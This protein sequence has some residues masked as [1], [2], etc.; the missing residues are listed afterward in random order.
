MHVVI[1]QML[2]RLVFGF[3]VFVPSMLFAQTTSD[4][5]AD[6]CASV[7]AQ[8]DAQ[9]KAECAGLL[10][11]Q[12]TSTKIKGEKDSIANEVKA[13]DTQIQIAQQKIKVQNRII[14]Q[15][16]KDI[17]VKTTTVSGLESR[18]DKNVESVGRV[19]KSLNDTDAVSLPEI[20]LG[21]QGFS[22]SYIEVNQ[23]QTLNRELTELINEV[24]TQKKHFAK[25]N[26]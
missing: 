20:L 18:I 9:A 10:V 8:G 21:T 3:F 11:L 14:D 25:K 19:I 6:F 15:L 4:P 2:L 12:N 23:M 17:K 1:R 24:K 22:S 26:R 13:I 7:S 5:I 16:T